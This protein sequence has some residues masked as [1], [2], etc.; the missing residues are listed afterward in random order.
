[1][2]VTYPKMNHSERTPHRGKVIEQPGVINYTVHVEKKCHCVS[3]ILIIADDRE[4]EMKKAYFSKLC[5]DLLYMQSCLK[6]HV[7]CTRY[8]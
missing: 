1:M 5:V 4:V 7:L 6:V 3:E 8:F 2:S